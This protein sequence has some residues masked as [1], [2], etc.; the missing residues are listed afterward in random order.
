VYAQSIE[1]A[2]RELGP[3]DDKEAHG[4]LRRDTSGLRC[5]RRSPRGL[6]TSRDFIPSAARC[7]GSK[8]ALLIAL[9]SLAWA[10]S[11]RP[12]FAEGATRDL[13]DYS[14]PG[15]TFTVSIAI[16]D[17]P[18]TDLVGVEEA[19]PSG[20]TVSAISNGGEWDEQNAEVKWLFFSPSIP[21]AVTYD[22]TP[23]GD[24]SGLQCF[25]GI[26]N[27]DGVEQ[28]IAGDQCLSVTIP[29]LC[30]WGLVVLALLVLTAGSTLLIRPH[31]A[32]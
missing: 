31:T 1:L 14:L 7:A 19:P 26:A 16:D 20:W 2:N 28:P 9:C 10:G 8:N 5:S 29:T 30:E 32:G 6:P 17:D 3:S 23:P 18:T 12:V 24:A 11:A 27:F 22:L 15:V 4:V 13:S 21:S 25:S